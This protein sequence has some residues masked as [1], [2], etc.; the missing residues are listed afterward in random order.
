MLDDITPIVLTYNEQANIQRTLSA[1][2]WAKRVLI[3][4]SFSSDETLQLCESFEN[5]HVVQNEFINFAQQCN[6]ALS[7]DINTE[8][9][10][11]MDADY[12]VTPEL[13][14]EFSK[15]VPTDNTNGYK[16]SFEYLINGQALRGSLYPARTCLYRQKCAHYKQD[17][18]AHRVNISGKVLPLNA[19]LQHDDRKP[20]SRW[21]SS[22]KKYAQQE[23][24][25]L[26]ASSW[27]DLSWPDRLRRL[28]IAPFVVLPYTLFIKGLI[29]NG[30]TGFEYSRQRFIAELEL[31]KA[32]F[33]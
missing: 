22:Q 5:V 25:K 2:R 31:Q 10:L 11:S 1:L 21:L 18:H 29:L 9:V 24:Q 14:N 33:K 8:W 7:Q 27:H 17:G 16:I 19:K 15:L 32:R 20:Y 23:I 28:G 30:S 4:D 6:F 26:T 3:I 13:Q 12:V